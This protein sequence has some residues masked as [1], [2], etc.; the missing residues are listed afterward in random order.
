[1]IHR[2]GQHRLLA[3]IFS[4]PYLDTDVYLR[5]A[6]KNRRQRPKCRFWVTPGR[7]EVCWQNFLDKILLFQRNDQ[8]SFACQ[9]KTFINYVMKVA[10]HFGIEACK[11][12]GLI[13]HTADRSSMDRTD[14][15][16]PHVNRVFIKLEKLCQKQFAFK[17]NFG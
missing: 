9:K 11:F 12:L 1:M 16:S 17:S 6:V 15:V 2:L 7:T 10:K 5:L 3:Q 14:P 4:L 8:K 13:N